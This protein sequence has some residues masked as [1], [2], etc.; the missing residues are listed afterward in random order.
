MKAKT[1]AIAVLASLPLLA[2]I[3]PA[4]AQMVAPPPP[5]AE[6]VPPPPGG[7]YV[8]WQPGR[9]RWN[10]VQ[11]VWIP[12]HYARPPY[13]RAVWVPGRWVLVR[14]RWIWRDGHWRR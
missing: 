5:Q 11:Y 4:H 12:G 6:A 2:S 9:W 13:A 7:P 14:G 3:V 10:G 1:L 8:V